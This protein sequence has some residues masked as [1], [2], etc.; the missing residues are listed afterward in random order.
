[1]IFYQSHHTHSIIRLLHVS[2]NCDL[3]LN[4][5]RS[6]STIALF[7]NDYILLRSKLNKLHRKKP[8]YIFFKMGQNYFT[9]IPSSTA[10][11]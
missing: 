8:N 11:M 4:C 3:F 7:K 6:S 9:F 1:M 2:F 5:C 10:T